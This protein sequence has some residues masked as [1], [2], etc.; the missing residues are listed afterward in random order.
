MLEVNWEEL[1]NDYINTHQILKARAVRVLVRLK[2][3]RSTSSSFSESYYSGDEMV[4][5]DGDLMIMEGD[6]WDGY[7]F[8]AVFDHPAYFSDDAL[9]AEVERICEEKE[10]KRL[11]EEERKRKAAEEKELRKAEKAKRE[12]LKKTPEYQE[13]LR[14]RKI[15]R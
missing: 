12:E 14:L 13:Y 9:H 5:Q 8:T 10:R 7:S 1:L 3:A 6:S 4:F 11:E 2:N 15:F